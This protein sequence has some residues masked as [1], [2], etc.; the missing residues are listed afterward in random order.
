MKME[1]GTM[2]AWLLIILIFGAPVVIYGSLVVGAI[3]AWKEVAKQTDKK[4]DDG[5][6]AM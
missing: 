6:W 5:F 4:L 2:L 1:V 3:W